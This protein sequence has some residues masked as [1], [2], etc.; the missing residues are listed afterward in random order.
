M[1][2]E[3]KTLANSE[4]FPAGVGVAINREMI[5]LVDNENTEKEHIT[6][7]DGSLFHNMHDGFQHAIEIPQTKKRPMTPAEVNR[8]WCDTIRRNDGYPAWRKQGYSTAWFISPNSS[9]SEKLEYTTNYIG[10]Y[11]EWIKLEVEVVE[12]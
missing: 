6:S 3:F 2:K 10:E 8:W 4:Q 5:V 11:T 9:Y 1:K 7:W 12:I